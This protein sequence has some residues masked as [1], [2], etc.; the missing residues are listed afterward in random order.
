MA[1]LC[2]VD[3]RFL[4]KLDVCKRCRT[5]SEMDVWGSVGAIGSSVSAA[6][7]SSDLGAKRSGA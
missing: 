3:R 5:F 7:V 1:F 4:K 6:V 2:W